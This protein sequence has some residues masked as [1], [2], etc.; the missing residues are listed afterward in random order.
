MP[1]ARAGLPYSI[2]FA[3]STGNFEPDTKSGKVLQSL[4]EIGMN[5]E[6]GQKRPD[7]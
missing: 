2:F 4:T 1:F 5:S 7:G 6:I 3:F